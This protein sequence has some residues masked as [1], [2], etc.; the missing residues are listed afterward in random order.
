[1]ACEK[2]NGVVEQVDIPHVVKK[3]PG[4]ERELRVP[5]T[6]GPHGR[7]FTINPG[8]TFSIPGA[9]IKPAFNPLKSHMR[10]TRF[11][12]D[13]LAREYFVGQMPRDE[14]GY[15]ASASEL[16]SRAESM[17]AAFE[18]LRGLDLSNPDDSEKVLK[19]MQEHQTSAEFWAMLA[20]T[21]VAAAR[22]AVRS[23]NPLQAAWAASNAERCRA[24][25]IFKEALEEV[26]LMGHSAARV[27]DVL[28]TW[29]RN[30]E[31]ADEEFWQLT[32]N[33]NT[34]V[35]SQVFAVPVVFVKDKAYV[36]GQKLD[37][38][39]ARFV[40]YLFSTES[41]REAILIEIK[42]PTTPLLAS[43]YRGVRPPSRDLAGSVVQVQ[44][45]RTELVRNLRSL[46]GDGPGKALSA[47]FPR[48]AVIIGNGETDLK[49]EDA[50]KS[51]ETFRAGLKDVE[52]I[53]FD[54]LFRKVEILAE[55][56]SLKRTETTT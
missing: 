55:L 31:S 30:R 52:V 5:P 28:M 33:E 12:V 26:V 47:F 22:E 37:R 48:C 46:V 41:S 44:N 51:F 42:T 27:V 40:D 29:E 36:G 18:P 56:F 21:Y 54:E 19:I 1:M 11:G 39:D 20:S 24:M 17:L 34:Y 50:R 7:G 6:P 25:I 53:T 14:A 35:L 38:S 16:E 13:H 8:E 10:L 43:E 49:E 23:G 4:C 2:C 32:L 9:W 45:Y 15:E 3:C